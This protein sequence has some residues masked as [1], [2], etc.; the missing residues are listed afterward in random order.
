MQNLILPMTSPVTRAVPQSP[1]KGHGPDRRRPTVM[2]RWTSRLLRG[3]LSILLAIAVFPGPAVGEDS[4]P[5]E[6][7]GTA[8]GASLDAVGELA[9]GADLL[10]G[11]PVFE[12]TEVRRGQRGYGLS[13][14]AG[15]TPERFEVEVL[16]V[17]DHSTPELSYILAR[18]GG[19]GLE[20]SGVAAGM[21]GSPVYLEGKLAGAV[22]F[23]YQFGLEA[24]AGITPIQA[25]R[26]LSELPVS[27]LAGSLP[28]SGDRSTARS[29]TARSSTTGGG[30]GNPALVPSL[31]QLI[32]GELPENLLALHLGLLEPRRASRA[33]GEGVGAPAWTWTAGG[34]GDRAAGLLRG[35]VGSL[36]PRVMAGSR[37]HGGGD[38]GA[39]RE[40]ALAHLAG[41][42]AVAAVLV[43]GDLHLAAHG[44]VTERR[45]DEI[46]A[47]G[48]PM[49]GLGPVAVPLAASEV[50]T[51]I[52]NVA[53]SFKVSNTGAILGVFDQD[54]E[55]GVRGR[56]GADPDMTPLK[57]RLRSSDGRETDYAM[58]VAEIQMMRPLLL[59]V[60]TLG[61][62]DAGSYSGG[63]QGIDLA[64][65][66]T[67]AGEGAP[68][69]LMLTQTFDGDSAG[70]DAALY[71]LGVAA[72]LDFNPWR[73]I[74]YEEVEVEF[75]QVDRPR[76]ATLVAGHASRRKLAPGETL[77]VTLELDPYRGE[78][79]RQEVEVRIPDDAPAGRYYLFLGDGSSLDAVRSAVEKTTP[80]TFGQALAAVRSL[81]SRGELLVYGM[82]SRPGLSLAGEAMPGLPGSFRSIFGASRQTD[83]EPL[84]LEI[85][86][87]DRQVLSAPIEGAVRLDLE[88]E[89][90][91]D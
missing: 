56:L 2:R 20:Q 48:H 84:R 13:V 78:R 34:F 41:G 49:F 39:A 52:S 24:I 64:L 17:L 26:R 58:R 32:S 35:A 28:A 86:Q 40:A 57:V 83:L 91:E 37:A 70:S 74:D 8:N 53:N 22:A 7:G 45:G 4:T 54:R 85:L 10:D 38:E 50:V 15:E 82:V 60:A 65:R 14:F 16:G 21:S 68:D 29:S 71:L 55:A 66:F 90:P 46:L 18:L 30:V 69:D 67:F 6:Q 63:Y 11:G 3:L 47:F 80:E 43:D 27:P 62:L 12:L 9:A 5:S 25:M 89:V 19:Q 59:T 75:T 72:F 76:S 81:H 61:A 42:S 77:R 44:T 1:R 31:D 88:I 87:R 33:L 79:Q 36:R 73:R 51:V 23:S